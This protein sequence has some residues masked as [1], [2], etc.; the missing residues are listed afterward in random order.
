MGEQLS[1]RRSTRQHAAFC[2]AE[3]NRTFRGEHTDFQKISLRRETPS[4]FW[5]VNQS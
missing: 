4:I 2:L 1:E 5:S 3:P